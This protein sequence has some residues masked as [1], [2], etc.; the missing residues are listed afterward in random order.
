MANKSKTTTIGKLYRK[1]NLIILLC[2]LFLS[3]SIVIAVLTYYGQSAGGFSIRL[4]EDAEAAGLE[5]STDPN[6][7][8]YSTRLIADSV[9]DV[10]PIS[11]LDLQGDPVNE[12]KNTNGTYIPSTTRKGFVGYTFYVR[13]V[14]NE[15]AVLS[16]NFNLTTNDSN[17]NCDGDISDAIWVWVFYG[18]DDTA[19]TIYQKADTKTTDYPSSYPA[20]TNFLNDTRVF[21]R[22]NTRI[23]VGETFKISVIVWLEGYDPDCVDSGEDSILGG[24]IRYAMQLTIRDAVI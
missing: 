20:R 5:L 22:S 14:G 3:L 9:Q 1:K 23:A 11:Y 18:E 17:D 6:F 2:L 19:G 8:T 4:S 21:T 7:N 10:Q 15:D 24:K 16:S 13:N 12:V